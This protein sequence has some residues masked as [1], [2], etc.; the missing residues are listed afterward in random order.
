MLRPDK[1]RRYDLNLLVTLHVL[2]EECS[3]SRA[4]RRLSLS[5]SAISRALGRLRD[6]FGDEL[7]IRRPHGLQ[8]TN[9]ALELQEELSGTLG[10][11]SRLVE[12]PKFDPFECS[13]T[14]N[15]SLMEH[16]SVQLLPRLLTYLG[17]VAPG[18]R[19]HLTTW[20]EESSQAMSTG[21][22]D[23]CINI[24][25]QD[26]PDL[27]QRRI[28]PA[29]PVIF[30]ANDHPLATKER[31]NMDE[32][33]SY[34]HISLRYYEFKDHPLMQQLTEM[35]LRRDVLLTAT[36]IHAA[37]E[38][39]SK[40]RSLMIGTLDMCEP[41]LERHHLSAVKLPVELATLDSDYLL[42]WHRLQHRNPEQAWFR[43]VLFDHCSA[44]EKAAVIEG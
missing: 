27:Y 17:R 18:V 28:G 22:L 12:P 37:L 7:F 15:I 32:F 23:A 21:K 30:L 34:P 13:Q 6:V 44:L 4:A 9:R 10:Q 31:L 3:V 40:T 24:A 1:L 39:V 5:Q 43:S 8:P 42:T 20:N 11:V 29:R 19:L 2:L 26:R 16:L 35:M 36:D 38:V 14:F 41:L 33:L 25:V